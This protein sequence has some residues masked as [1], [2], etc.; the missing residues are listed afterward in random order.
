MRKRDGARVIRS[1]DCYSLPSRMVCLL[2]IYCC[3]GSFY[4]F[5]KESKLVPHAFVNASQTINDLLGS[6][7]SSSVTLAAGISTRIV[8]NLYI[9]PASDT[10]SISHSSLEAEI[11]PNPDASSSTFFSF[12]HL[13]YS[14]L[15]QKA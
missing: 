7:T 4:L 9:S 8:L 15:F 1:S 5:L 12:A 2:G 14:I 11:E 10:E 13:R 6:R 3:T